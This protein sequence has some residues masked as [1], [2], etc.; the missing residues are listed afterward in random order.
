M[1]AQRDRATIPKG[2]KVLAP[3]ARAL[4]VA[5]DAE[6]GGLGL[7]FADV[8]EQL[9]A[10]GRAKWQHLAKEYE[11]NP[12][13]F[14]EG[15]RMA[16]TAYC[17]WSSLYLAAAADIKQRGAVVEGRSAEDRGRTVRNPYVQF[18]RE[19]SQQLRY[20][21]REL[22]LTPDSRGRLGLADGE[23]PEDTDNP[24]A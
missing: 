5:R 10:T 4:A 20:W 3:P 2:L 21:C 22:G 1:T 19:A 8:P 15:D 7:N 23:T 18:A 6:L 11:Q 9:D 17:M 16:V 14:R 24:F 13:R 12:T